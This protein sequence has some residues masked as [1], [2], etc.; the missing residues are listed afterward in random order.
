MSAFDV[1]Q[2]REGPSATKHDGIELAKIKVSDEMDQIRDDLRWLDE[3]LEFW[4]EG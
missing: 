3:M 1:V 2:G 4:L